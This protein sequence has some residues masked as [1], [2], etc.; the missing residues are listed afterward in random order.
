MKLGNILLWVAILVIAGL[1]VRKLFFGK[2]ESSAA[3]GSGPVAARLSGFVVEPTLSETV[4]NASGTL[5]SSE[6]VIL[7][8]ETSGKIVQLNIR[9]GEKVGEGAGGRWV[10]TRLTFPLSHPP[11]FLL[12]NLPVSLTISLL[13]GGGG[14][15]PN[16]FAR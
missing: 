9:E 8:A 16:P 12:R 11:T 4:I 15:F 6:E 14:C 7:R 1:V 10:P 3:K 5:I 2:D 13:A